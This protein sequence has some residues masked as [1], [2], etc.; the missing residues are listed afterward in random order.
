MADLDMSGVKV[1]V[2]HDPP[3]FL[4]F[5][6]LE[7]G[8]FFTNPQTLGDPWDEGVFQKLD[9]YNALVWRPITQPPGSPTHS[10]PAGTKTLWNKR[11]EV[12]RIKVL[13]INFKG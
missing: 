3:K 1:F 5:G 10:L 8:E 12:V 6:D 13:S 9:M 2:I 11:S 4:T 7:E